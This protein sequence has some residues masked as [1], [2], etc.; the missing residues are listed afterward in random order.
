MSE[1]NHL[2]AA[3]AD[4]YRIVLFTAPYMPDSTSRPMENA[5]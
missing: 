3:L 1:S 4:R 5:S 2:A